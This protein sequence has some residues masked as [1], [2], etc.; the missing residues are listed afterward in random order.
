MRSASNDPSSGASTGR[1][2]AT[3]IVVLAVVG[4]PALVLRAFCAG[5]SCNDASAAAAEVPF[6]PLPAALREA[7]G[8]GFRQGRS[9]DVLAAAASTPV[10]TAVPGQAVA[11]P[12]TSASSPATAPLAFLGPNVTRGALPSGTGLDDVAP[13]VAALLGY[14]PPHPEVRA[15]RAI[16]GVASVGAPPD[17]LGVEI[18]WKGVG[19]DALDGRWPPR[20]RR[21][22]AAAGASTLH[23]TVGSLPL[24]PAAILTTIG[25]GGLPAQHGITGT[26][27]RTARGGVARAWSTGAPE[28][29]I[30]SLPDDLDR[31]FGDRA[32]VG[33]VASD[34][35]D[36]GLIGDGWYL[37]ADRDQVVV[38]RSDPAAA[39]VR[40]LSRG[41]GADDVPDI[42]GVVLR[43][44]LPLLDRE[45]GAILEAV[46]ARVP[47]ALVA[48]T[49]TGDATTVTGAVPGT[50]VG[51]DVDA[52]LGAAVV[53][54]DGAGGVFLDASALATA[55]LSADAAVQAMRA[56]TDADGSPRFA[57]VYPAFSVAFARYC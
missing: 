51:H 9:P 8:A 30:T 23:A 43:G 20:T 40:M 21:L 11:W 28:A 14:A 45:T 33:L 42:L 55:R 19:S 57:D 52:A 26:D 22:V 6:C 18:V 17:L 13:T 7:I 1:R 56:Q 16:D 54:A 4:A 47:R 32:M 27:L 44:P 5:N 2:L 15:G 48:I 37:G 29:V 36:L 53:Q 46:R 49:A 50:T 41:F 3:L 39:T 31:S 10:V 25:T 24:D 35:T 34:P 38:E 12:S